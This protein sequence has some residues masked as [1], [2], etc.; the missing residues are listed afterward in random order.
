MEQVEDGRTGLLFENENTNSMIEAINRLE[1]KEL[2]NQLC[3]NARSEA[4]KFSWQKP[5]EQILE[6]Y[7]ETL[8]AYQQNKAKSRS[9]RK[10]KIKV[11]E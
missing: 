10:S 2:Y 9:S 7:H 5:S 1:D 8:E 6:F 11:T 4:E 3:E